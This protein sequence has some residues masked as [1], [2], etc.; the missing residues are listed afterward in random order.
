MTGVR[1]MSRDDG[2]E[3]LRLARAGRIAQAAD[4][5]DYKAGVGEIQAAMRNG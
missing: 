4:Q 3:M 2:G 5:K 1:R